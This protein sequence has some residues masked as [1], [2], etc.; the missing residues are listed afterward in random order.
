M[1]K[2]NSLL[3]FITEKLACS[4][5]Q[6]REKQKGDPVE[7]VNHGSASCRLGSSST[8]NL[9]HTEEMLTVLRHLTQHSIL[10]LVE[11]SVK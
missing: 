5:V 10:L 4:S 9:P 7:R 2:G 3:Q 1:G 6:I 11:M 8:L